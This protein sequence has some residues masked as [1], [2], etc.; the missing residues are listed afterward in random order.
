MGHG[1]SYVGKQPRT[2]KQSDCSFRFDIHLGSWCLLQEGHQLL[3]SNQDLSSYVSCCIC[4]EHQ[5]S[6]FPGFGISHSQQQLLSEL[7][8]PR[9][10]TNLN[11]CMGAVQTLH[12]MI[13]QKVESSE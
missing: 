9:V 11:T 12:N 10:Y 3:S 13:I 2:V 8:E 4:H 6:F 5:H 1:C 7:S